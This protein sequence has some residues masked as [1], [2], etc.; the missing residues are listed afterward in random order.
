MMK[1]HSSPKSIPYRNPLKGII[2]NTKLA[3]FAALM[4]FSVNAQGKIHDTLTKG[5]LEMQKTYATKIVKILKKN[6][7]YQPAKDAP[8]FLI[9]EKSVPN[10][11][12]EITGPEISQKFE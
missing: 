12:T 3:L 9:E 10:T 1:L 2:G 6:Q 8:K 4:T 5:D 11:Q 7:M